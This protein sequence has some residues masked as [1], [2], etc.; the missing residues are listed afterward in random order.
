M[1]FNP[2]GDLD[3]RIDLQKSTTGHSSTGAPITTWSTV[4]TVSAEF[5]PATARE[6]IAGAAEVSE[7][8]A[9]FRI[10]FRHDVVTTWRVGYQGQFWKIVGVSE[11]GRHEGLE[12]Q[13][14]AIL[15]AAA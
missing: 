10:R 3:R 9:V 12:L 4:A 15:Q 2:A 14:T 11:I 5:R 6:F 7:Q 13:A 1:A 8:R